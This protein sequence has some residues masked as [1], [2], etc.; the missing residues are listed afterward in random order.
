M[1]DEQ[2]DD[3]GEDEGGKASILA[4]TLKKSGFLI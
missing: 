2:R 3:R 4:E 1:A